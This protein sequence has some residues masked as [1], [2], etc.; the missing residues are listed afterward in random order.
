MSTKIGIAF[1]K[2]G[3]IP[4]SILKKDQDVRVAPHE[5]IDVPAAYGKHLIDDKFAYVKDVEKAPKS[6]KKESAAPA[7]PLDVTNQIAT[8]EKA[9]ADADAKLAAA[10]E[11]K[12]AK[13]EAGREIAA[14][15]SALK[16]LKG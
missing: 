7:I 1:V 5:A 15:K 16:K 10:G 9:L 2:G 11:D 13:A 14:A 4:A 12:V 3:I 8:A 6:G